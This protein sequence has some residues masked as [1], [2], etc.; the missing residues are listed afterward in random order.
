MDQN[1]QIGNGFIII[2]LSYNRNLYKIIVE[3][4]PWIVLKMS[5]RESDGSIKSAAHNNAIGDGITD[6]TVIGDN[7][8]GDKP[9]SQRLYSNY[10]QVTV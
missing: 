10:A 6:D 4:N 2:R 1:V 7:Q 5:K 9:E 8:L 3:L